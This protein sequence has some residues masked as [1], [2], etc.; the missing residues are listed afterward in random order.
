MPRSR[1][2]ISDAEY[3]LL[4][5]LRHSLRLFA[6]FSEQ[7]ARRAALA[8][9]QHQALLALKG[10]GRPQPL[11]IGELAEQL[12]IRHH[13]AVGLVQRL[14][15]RGLIQR[16]P[17]A[18]DRRRV[19]LVLRPRGEAL[20]AKLSAAHRDELRRIGPQIEELLER[21]RAGNRTRKRGS[22]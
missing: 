13:S 3:E 9:V 15:A 4:A 8:P 19:R 11:T 6:G 10:H 18:R 5:Q 21:L 22:S 2:R 1:T 7:A 16:S 17:D 12:L 14:L 20:L